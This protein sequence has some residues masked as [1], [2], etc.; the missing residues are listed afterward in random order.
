MPEQ[1][2]SK[3]GILCPECKQQVQLDDIAS[4]ADGELRISGICPK[5]KERVNWRVF[6][7][8]LAHQALCND[9]ARE[10]QT[11]NPGKRVPP[12]PL[13]PPLALPAPPPKLT[14]QD[15]RQLRSW[16]IAP[17]EDGLLQ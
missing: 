14:A 5:C 2:W 1:A 17:P 8:Q 4:S 11:P 12:Q 9:L 13:Q 3:C 16:A 10:Q 6:A 7:S 15:I